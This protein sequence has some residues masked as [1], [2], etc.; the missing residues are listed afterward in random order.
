MLVSCNKYLFLS[1]GDFP[2]HI[3][4]IDIFTEFVE[5]IYKKCPNS[6]SN[7][8]HT[9]HHEIT[10]KISLL[11]KLTLVRYKKSF[12]ILIKLTNLLKLKYLTFFQ[13]IDFLVK[14]LIINY[15]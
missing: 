4:V 14:I 5:L 1:I 6:E 7:I 3:K 11:M 13:L 12:K 15:T 2:K 9:T 8:T 10:C